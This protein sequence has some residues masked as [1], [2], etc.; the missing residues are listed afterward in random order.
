VTR[1]DEGAFGTRRA[2]ARARAERLRAHR[3]GTIGLALFV[4][5]PVLGFAGVV[6]GLVL[7]TPGPEWW[8]LAIPGGILVGLAL[9]R[10]GLRMLLSAEDAREAIAREGDPADAPAPTPAPRP[11]ASPDP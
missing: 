4:G 3:R 6:T 1:D 5:G 10:I 7:G 11:D 2:H 9:H 8:L